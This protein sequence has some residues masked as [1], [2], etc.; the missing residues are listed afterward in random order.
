MCLLWLLTSQVCVC[1]SQMY[2]F[3]SSLYYH[4]IY[5]EVYKS[6]MHLKVSES[7]RGGKDKNERSLFEKFTIQLFQKI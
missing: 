6:L 4:Y 2:E 7:H 5:V 1:K 3:S